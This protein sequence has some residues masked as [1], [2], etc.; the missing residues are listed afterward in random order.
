MPG[1]ELVSEEGIENKEGSNTGVERFT[2]KLE[3]LSAV[4]KRNGGTS[5]LE[6]GF[7]DQER[8]GSSEE[9]EWS[10]LKGTTFPNLI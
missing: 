10:P 3:Y 9:R 2:W 5:N 8:V 4:G 6:T 7:N 1:N